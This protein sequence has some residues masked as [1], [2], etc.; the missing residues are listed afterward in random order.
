LFEHGFDV[1]VVVDDVVVGDVV[2]DDDDVVVVKP[3]PSPPPQTA[4]PSSPLCVG[5]ADVTER[6][7]RVSSN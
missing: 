6:T 2:A 5:A 4:H 3:S 7:T 1:G